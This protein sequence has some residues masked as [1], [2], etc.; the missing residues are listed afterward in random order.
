M[1]EVEVLAYVFAAVAFFLLVMLFATRSTLDSAR[2][3]LR[4]LDRQL[5]ELSSAIEDLKTPDIK[6]K[7]KAKAKVKPKAEAKLKSKPEA[8][9]TFE[10]S[11]EAEIVDTTEEE[12]DSPEPYVPVIVTRTTNPSRPVRDTWREERAWNQSELYQLLRLYRDGQEVIHIATA[13]TVDSKD[14]VFCV[15]RNVFSCQGNL[16]DTSI[17]QNDKKKWQT[18]QKTQVGELIMAGTPI[19]DLAN[20]FGR[21]QLAIVWQYID[22]G[23]KKS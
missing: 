1:R 14:V 5:Q 16:E 4:R 6:Q 12:D 2:R 20:K 9:Q 8:A 13:M 19:K 21:T 7:T 23:Y 17:A 11:L 18:I 22:N 3:Q 10:K 15:A